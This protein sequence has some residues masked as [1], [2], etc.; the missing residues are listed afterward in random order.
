MK[1]EKCKMGRV[2]SLTLTFAIC[3]LHF[4]FIRDLNAQAPFYQDKTISVFVGTKAGDVYDLYAR[5][6]AQLARSS[7]RW[8]KRLA[9]SL[10]R[11]WNE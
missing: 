10:R 11:S 3:I 8:Q 9:T 6:L 7:T 2:N 4:T 5:L 1:R